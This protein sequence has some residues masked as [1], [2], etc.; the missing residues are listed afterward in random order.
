[1]I[2][3]HNSNV[4]PEVPNSRALITTTFI[5]SF[6]DLRRWQRRWLQG[7]IRR[8]LTCTSVNDTH[9]YEDTRRVESMTYTATT[10]FDHTIPTM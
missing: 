8:Q 1:M 9:I 2:N 7:F 3:E 5:I 4:P 6:D 10:G